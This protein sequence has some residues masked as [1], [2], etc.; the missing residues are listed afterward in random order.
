MPT[1]LMP[2]TT[3]QNPQQSAGNSNSQVSA[4]STSNNSLKS[5]PQVLIK[6]IN[7]KVT[8]TPVPG[9]G[10]TPAVNTEEM[11]KK[12]QNSTKNKSNNNN[13]QNNHTISAGNSNSQQV[14]GK[15]SPPTTVS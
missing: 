3:Q 13:N 5:G 7:G 10:A 4:D 6:N 11:F 2:S 8:I 12:N 14:N 15:K 1:Y 9:T